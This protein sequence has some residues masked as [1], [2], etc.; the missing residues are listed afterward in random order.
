MQLRSYSFVI[1][2]PESGTV[3]RAMPQ[4]FPIMCAEC[5]DRYGVG[6]VAA[7]FQIDKGGGPDPQIQLW[8]RSRS[9]KDRTG[10]VE[11]GEL[12]AIPVVHCRQGTHLFTGIVRGVI[13]R[14]VREAARDGLLRGS[15]CGFLRPNQD[16]TV[17]Q[18]RA[19]AR[20]AARGLTEAIGLLSKRL[21]EPALMVQR[22]AAV[23]MPELPK[24]RFGIPEPSDREG[25]AVS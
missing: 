8:H 21:G 16:G 19:E 1:L 4:W 12:A 13:E 20:E 5:A 2:S 9:R 14:R 15:A 6:H 25:E 24:L 18:A 23:A 11:L 17:G 7:T 10:W 22:L 3:N